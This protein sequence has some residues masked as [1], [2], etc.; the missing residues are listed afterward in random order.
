MPYQINEECIA[1]GV[2]EPDCDS[3]AI[4]RE[5]DSYIIN[6]YA[7]TECG[8]CEEVCPTDGVNRE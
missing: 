3:Q 7:C 2:C 6:G 4:S 1:C 5:G 8:N